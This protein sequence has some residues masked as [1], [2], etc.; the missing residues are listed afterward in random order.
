MLAQNQ[1]TLDTTS[2]KRKRDCSIGTNGGYD[3]ENIPAQISLQSEVEHGY[4]RQPK[5]T[6]DEILR[7]LKSD[8]VR[9]RSF[10][11]RTE[12]RLEEIFNETQLLRRDVQALARP[13]PPG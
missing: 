6:A 1:F 13:H 12:Q 9:R 10:E 5:T 8:I 11:R 2:K 4:Y 7:M 3:R